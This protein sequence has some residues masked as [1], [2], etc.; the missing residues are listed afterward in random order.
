MCVFAICRTEAA[1]SRQVAAFSVPIVQQMDFYPLSRIQSLVISCCEA[2][3]IGT[4]TC[5]TSTGSEAMCRPGHNV[6]QQDDCEH[7]HLHDTSIMLPATGE[8]TANEPG[9]REDSKTVER[10]IN[11]SRWRS[12]RNVTFGLLLATTYFLFADQNLMAPNLTDIARSFNMTDLERDTKLGGEISLSLFLV[13]APVSLVV[14]FHADRVNRKKLYGTVV[15]LGETG[16]LL[17]AFVSKYWQL[18]VLRALTG[19]ALGGAMPLIYSMLADM[20]PASERP[21]ASAF[22]GLTMG[23]G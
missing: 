9:E 6:I 16:C 19:V 15:L 4:L 2:I 8:V 7:V 1:R 20:Y 11:V 13:G 17:T 22:V 5:C 10:D 12:E 14:G 3:N 23:M 21:R 18:F